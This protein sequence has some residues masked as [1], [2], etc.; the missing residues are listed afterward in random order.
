[1][2]RHAAALTHALGLPVRRRGDTDLAIEDRKFSGNAQHRG[3][4]ALLFHGTI[5][6]ACDLEL[7]EAVLPPPSR[8]PDYRAN[9]QHAA[10][11]RPPGVASGRVKDALRRAWEDRVV[12]Q[13]GPPDSIPAGQGC[14]RALPPASMTRLGSSLAPPTSSRSA[15]VTRP[16]EPSDT[17]VPDIPDWSRAV[18][19]ARE[20]AR[21]KYDT[22]DWTFRF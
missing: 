10:F 17:A 16:L 5:L 9:R 19:R 3:R 15:E 14:R 11:L 13:P 6:C 18:S 12:H 8:Q 22:H 2:N 20:L 4:H 1:M 7:M 21:T